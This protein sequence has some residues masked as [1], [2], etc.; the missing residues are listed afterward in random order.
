M[1][2]VGVFFGGRIHPPSWEDSPTIVGRFTHHGLL[3]CQIW[4]QCQYALEPPRDKKKETRQGLSYQFKHEHSMENSRS[5]NTKYVKRLKDEVMK[6]AMDWKLVN[7]ETGEIIEKPMVDIVTHNGRIKPKAYFVK[8][9]HKWPHKD[10]KVWLMEACGKHVKYL[11]VI[12]SY[13]DTDNMFNVAAFRHEII[14]DKSDYSKFKKAM[15]SVWM[16]AEKD[17]QTFVNPLFVF[18]WE[19]ISIELLSLFK[20]DYKNNPI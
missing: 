8:M 17:G 11:C 12:P 3:Y 15:L 19:T 10:Y 5:V 20:Y 14:K 4:L 13:C 7:I 6:M 9:M 18:Q 2:R 16:F 1:H